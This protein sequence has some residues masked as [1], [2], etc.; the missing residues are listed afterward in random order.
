MAFNKRRQ[1]QQPRRIDNLLA[2]FRRQAGRDLA[3]NA[4][5]D[6]DILRFLRILD[7]YIFNQHTTRPFFHA[8]TN[9]YFLRVAISQ[10]RKI[11]AA[12]TRE[13]TGLMPQVTKMPTSAPPITAKIPP[14]LTAA[15]L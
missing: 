3:E 6:A 4:V 14:I 8:D 11:T 2:R 5:S 9:S 1:S 12:T 7:V 10:I 13:L 15:A